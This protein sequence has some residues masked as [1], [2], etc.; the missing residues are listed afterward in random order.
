MFRVGHFESRIRVDDV[1]RITG[2][3][4]KRN[5]FLRKN[6]DNGSNAQVDGSGIRAYGVLVPRVVGDP[7]FFSDSPRRSKILKF[8]DRRRRSPTRA[9]RQLEQILNTLKGGVLRGKFKR[10]HA[11]SG[12]W[13]VD[14]FFPKIRLAIEVDGS[15]HLTEEQAIRDREKDADC[16][17]LDI[18]VLRISNHEVFG[19]RRKLINKLRGGWRRALDRENQIIGKT[20]V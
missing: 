18:T 8:A 4:K 17:R 20:P 12:K 5:R 10:E 16:A 7:G 14:F 15:A 3:K 13:I 11:V 2:R 6:A 1:V 9:E 19:N